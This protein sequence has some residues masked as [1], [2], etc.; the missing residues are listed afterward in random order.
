MLLV[1]FELPARMWQNR[2]CQGLVGV[3]LILEPDNLQRM[4]T[5]DPTDLLLSTLCRPSQ[6]DR[7]I[8]D[9]ALV[10]AYEEERTRVLEFKERNDFRGLMLWIE[11]GR[12]SGELRQAISA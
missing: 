1:H 8:R 6:T 4:R 12:Y 2:P 10:I 3:V 7:P 9:L 5:A 11:R